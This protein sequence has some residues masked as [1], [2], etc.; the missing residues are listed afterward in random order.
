M[1]GSSIYSS[2]LAFHSISNIWRHKFIIY[3]YTIPI[4]F[5]K[6]HEAFCLHFSRITKWAPFLYIS[7]I[8]LGISTSRIDLQNRENMEVA[9]KRTHFMLH[10]VFMIL[11]LCVASTSWVL[12]VVILSNIQCVGA[13]YSR[14]HVLFP[15]KQIIF[16]LLNSLFGS[17]SWVGPYLSLR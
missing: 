2:M 12:N 17:T 14:N 13:W 1:D 10:W 9:L 11:N 15:T 8:Q 6:N 4:F 3:Y 16:P 5:K 7:Q